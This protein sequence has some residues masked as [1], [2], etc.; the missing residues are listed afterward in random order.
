MNWVQ[1]HGNKTFDLNP[2]SPSNPDPAAGRQCGAVLASS[3]TLFCALFCVLFLS[4]RRY[5]SSTDSQQDSPCVVAPVALL[6]CTDLLATGVQLIVFLSFPFCLR[7]LFLLLFLLMRRTTMRWQSP[8]FEFD[9]AHWSSPCIAFMCIS[10]HQLDLDTFFEPGL[11][12]GTITHLVEEALCLA[13][14]HDGR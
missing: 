13:A 11:R 3:A 12:T 7:F 10:F 5:I 9:P 2:S 8:S 6:S 14:L 1:S 4:S